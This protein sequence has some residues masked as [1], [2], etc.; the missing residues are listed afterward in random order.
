MKAQE[1]DQLRQTL[2][3]QAEQQRSQLLD[4]LTD[5]GAVPPATLAELASC[6][7]DTLLE[8]ALGYYS[9]R[10]NQ[11]LSQLERIAQGRTTLIIAHRLSTIRDA[12][13]ILV[14][15]SGRIVEQGSCPDVLQRPVDD[16]TRTLLAAVPRL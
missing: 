1:M 10:S 3:Q 4:A 13:L 8:F 6:S 11:A 16:Y 14:M 2:E 7:T 9:R 5:E 12:D 15:E